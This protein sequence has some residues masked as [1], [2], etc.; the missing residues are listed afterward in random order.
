[1]YARKNENGLSVLENAGKDD[2]TTSCYFGSHFFSPKKKKKRDKCGDKNK[3][4]KL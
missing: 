4:S 3:W 1:M 2:C